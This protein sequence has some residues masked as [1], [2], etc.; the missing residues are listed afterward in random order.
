V[1]ALALRVTTSCERKPP[2]APQTAAQYDP[3]LSGTL[4][5][6]QGAEAATRPPNEAITNSK[7]GEVLVE[8]TDRLPCLRAQ[9]CSAAVMASRSR[10][11]ARTCR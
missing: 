1:P 8:V 6:S 10:K 7:W 3:S 11:P 9:W 4:S 2:K 5:Y